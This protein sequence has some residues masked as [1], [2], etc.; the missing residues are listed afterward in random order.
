MNV[1]ITVPSPID[2][3]DA[4]V[5]GVTCINVTWNGPRQQ[6]LSGPTEDRTYFVTY[7]ES[8]SNMIFTQNVGNSMY[9]PIINASPEG[10]YSIEVN[11][12]VIQSLYSW[13]IRY[14][15]MCCLVP[16]SVGIMFL[17]TVCVGTSVQ[18]GIQQQCSC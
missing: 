12:Y 1:F 3:L 9:H 18:W 11:N 4:D 15:Y 17:F 10:N 7:S 13:Y 5:F 16:L 6:N 14:M 8:S 2:S